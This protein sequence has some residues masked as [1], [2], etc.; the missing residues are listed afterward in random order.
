MRRFRWLWIACLTLFLSGLAQA[1]W[2]DWLKSTVDEVGKPEATTLASGSLSNSQI[3][4][5]LKEAL[6]IGTQKAVSLLGR[7]GGFLNDRQ[8]RIPLPGPLEKLGKGLR[9]IGQDEL[10]DEFEQTINRAAERAV[11]ETLSILSSTIRKMSLED[12]RGILNGGDSAATEYFRER[13]SEQLTSAILPIIKDATRKV[14]VTA[15]YNDLVDQ[16]G[17][18]ADYIDMSSLDL[19]QYVTKKALDGLFLKLAEQERL[20]RSDPVARTTELLRTVFGR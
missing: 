8:V 10:V 19:D 11:P 6:A 20:I 5:G 14:G 18:M 16:A 17:F 3:V 12:A 13:G 15:A 7:Q 9:T 1:D 4:E 2:K